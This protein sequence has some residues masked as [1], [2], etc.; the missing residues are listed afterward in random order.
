MTPR[1]LFCLPH[2]AH[3]IAFTEACGSDSPQGG[4]G[5]S[6]GSGPATTTT[7]T[8]GTTTTTSGTTTTTSSTTTGSGGGS[9]GKPCDPTCVGTKLCDDGGICVCAPGW[10]L[11]GTDCVAVPVSD[12]T[13]RTKAEVCQALADATKPVAKEWIPGTMG[14]CDPGTVPLDAQLATL[15]YL[16]FYRWMV[17]VGPV[18]VTPQMAQA[19]QECAA[20]LNYEFGHSPSPT[21]MCYTALGAQGCSDSLI[22]GGFGLVG[23]IDG[24][25]LE[26]GQNF[27]H[28][29]NVLAVGRAGVW[30]G[31]SGASSDMHYGGAYP[32]L[33]SDP[34]FVAHPGPGLQVM[35]KVPLDWW[36][37]ERGAVTTPP[38]DA[39]VF[40]KGTNEEKPMKRQHHY[41]DFSS[42]Q[43]MGWVPVADTPYRVQLINDSMAVFAEFETTF[44][45]CP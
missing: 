22:A 42:F 23:Q 30:F 33:P 37:V 2:L 32:A 1:A 40:V 28:H 11:S 36:F 43:P 7:T 35:S 12:P 16:N 4:S 31:A 41:N 19:E 44:I 8:S 9:T 21:T 18:Q 17:G 20:I 34:S 13:K 39:R 15:R 26:T 29:R 3:S 38:L 14:A 45:T 24:Y 10:S 5:G 6:G 27:I 25:A